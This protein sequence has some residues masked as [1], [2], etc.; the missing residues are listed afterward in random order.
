MCVEIAIVT[1]VTDI[2][3]LVDLDGSFFFCLGFVFFCY[4]VRRNEKRDVTNGDRMRYICFFW[5]MVMR[6]GLE[7]VR[8]EM[9]VPILGTLLDYC[10]LLSTSASLA[11]VKMVKRFQA[12]V[13]FGNQS[14][15]Q[16]IIIEIV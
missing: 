6:R 12:V 4:L 7:N 10:L 16:V 14:I 1:Y 2:S 9:F 11:R 8:R 5:V 3:G 15:N 13:G